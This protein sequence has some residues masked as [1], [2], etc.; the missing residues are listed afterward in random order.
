MTTECCLVIH[1]DLAEHP[2]L[3]ELLALLR[4]RAAERTD[5][6]SLVATP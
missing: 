3:L 5:Q 6:S 1:R 4:R 2:R